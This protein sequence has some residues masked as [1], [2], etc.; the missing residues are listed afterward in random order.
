M[1]PHRA[2]P[3]QNSGVRRRGRDPAAKP[4]T[5]T[6]PAI[7]ANAS[8]RLGRAAWV[9]PPGSHRLGRTQRTSS[10]VRTGKA[11]SSATR[12]NSAIR[13]G[14]TPWNVSSIETL[15]AMLWIT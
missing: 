8:G 10:S 15:P 12:K 6:L 14:T 11:I 3:R 5:G 7:P 9:A 1:C 13:N 4:A 2:M